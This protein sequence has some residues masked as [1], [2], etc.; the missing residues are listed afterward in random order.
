MGLRSRD[1]IRMQHGNTA[2]NNMKGKKSNIKDRKL[3]ASSNMNFKK[4]D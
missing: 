1:M 4:R 3:D 2:M